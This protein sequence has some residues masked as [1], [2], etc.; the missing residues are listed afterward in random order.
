GTA[1]WDFVRSVK[2]AVGIPVIVNGD[3]ITEDDA[4]AALVKS[5]AD[6]VMIGRGCYGRP[7]FP[8]Q[9]A[10]ALRTGERLPDPPLAEQKR[11]MLGHYD[12]VLAHYGQEAGLR[13]ARKHLAW[14]SRGL[15]GS[16]EFRAVVN[17]LHAVPD[18]LD[19]I[20]RFYDPLIARGVMAGVSREAAL[21]E[22]A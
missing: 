3:I 14:Y 18:V 19:L 6:G 20:D 16:A 5:G 10:H 8:A 21:A 15:P 1:D 11:I 13:L 2:D 7:W 17:R 9:V 4:A 12:A 22:A